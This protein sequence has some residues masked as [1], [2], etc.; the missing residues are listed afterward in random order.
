M[1][2]STWMTLV[3]A[4]GVGSIVSAIVGWVSSKAVT[5]SEHRQDWINALRDD[6]VSYFKQIDQI[7]HAL[8]RI[9]GGTTDDLERLQSTRNEAMYVYRRILLRLNMTEAA[10]IELAQKLL[11]LQLVKGQSADPDQIDSAINLARIVLK[12]EWAV[13]KYGVFTEPMLALKSW[14]RAKTAPNKISPPKP[15]HDFP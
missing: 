8:Q 6:L 12:H 1:S 10:H 15:F 5:I 4:V 13:T 9:S 7:H 2:F 3:A 11:D 14:R